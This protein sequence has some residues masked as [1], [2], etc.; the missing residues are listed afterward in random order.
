MA[1]S[2]NIKCVIYSCLL[3]AQISCGG[4]G[5]SSAP[6]AP[7]TSSPP[8]PAVTPPPPESIQEVL[9]EGVTQ[10]V[11]GILVYIDEG[12]GK[13]TIAAAGVQDRGNLMPADPGALF[14]IASISKLFIAVAVTRLAYQNI[15]SVDD[16]LAESLPSVAGRI[17]NSESITIRNMVQ[18]RSGIPDFDSQSGFD[19][20]RSHS[21]IDRTLK[22]ALDLPE[23]FL[24]DARYEYSNTNYLLL[25]K[26]MDRALGYD[27]R[28]FIQDSILTPLGMLDTYSLLEEVDVSRL[29]RGYWNNRDRTEQDYVIPGGSMISTLLDT[30]NFLRALS[31]GGLLNDEEQKLYASLYWYSHSGW[32]PGYQSFA[33]YEDDSDT[34]VVLFGNRTGGNSESVMN[35]VNENV[36]RLLENGTTR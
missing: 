24:P 17:Q 12:Q 22:Y 20:E 13:V 31:S 15:I 18:H 7:P 5:G 21:D 28:A 32:L 36:F 35:S 8:P 30:A 14:K 2:I 3:L 6:P 9:D 11:D 23:D 10:G 1:Q 27:H 29:V 19:W 34:V 26:I 4:G 33:K 16:T 25:A